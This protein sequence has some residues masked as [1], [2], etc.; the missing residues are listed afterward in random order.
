MT[1]AMTLVRAGLIPQIGLPWRI[2]AL[3]LA[4]GRDDA[5]FVNAFANRHVWKGQ[6]GGEGGLTLRRRGRVS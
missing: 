1:G 3:Q 5:A 4:A 6:G 2:P